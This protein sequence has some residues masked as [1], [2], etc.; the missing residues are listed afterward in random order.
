MTNTIE[1]YKWSN[2]SATPASI[3][4]RGGLYALT[5]IGTFGTS[6]QLQR[7]SADG[8]T[9]VGVHTALT[10]AGYVSLQLSSGTY[11]LAITSVTAVYADLT[12][13]IEPV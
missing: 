4:V 10:A 5:V 1:V 11:Q 6:V 3:S 2:I 12:S 13:I 8:S 9:Y 7:L